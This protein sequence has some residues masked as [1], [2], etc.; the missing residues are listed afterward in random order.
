MVPYHGGAS[1]VSPE[2][3]PDVP[4]WAASWAR[5]N[6]CATSP[7]EAVVAADVARI[8]YTSC[9]DGAAVV[10]YRIQGGGHSWPGGKPLPE[11]LVGSTSN[12]VD[13]TSRMWAFFREHRL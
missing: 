10:L 8:E 3:F 13:A 4:T 6:R 1:W 12:G 7:V 9:A 5:R 2:G 11:W